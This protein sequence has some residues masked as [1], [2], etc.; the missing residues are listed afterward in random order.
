MSIR[1]EQVVQP[2]ASYETMLAEW[3]AEHRA[4]LRMSAIF[5]VLTF[6]TNGLLIRY[7]QAEPHTPAIWLLVTAL[8]FAVAV[9]FYL[10]SRMRKPLP[11]DVEIN[12][13]LRRG[14]GL[15][16]DVEGEGS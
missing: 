5:F 14:A 11:I 2:L 15:P 4:A 16:D 7:L 13:A 8:S 1:D 9:P 3:K 6:I 10:Q 12:K